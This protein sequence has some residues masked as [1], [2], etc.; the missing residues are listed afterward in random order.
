MQSLQQFLGLSLSLRITF[1]DPF[2]TAAS[3][4]AS[5]ETHRLDAIMTPVSVCRSFPVFL[6]PFQ[7]P[8]FSARTPQTTCL[9]AQWGAAENT[10]LW[11]GTG[12]S[13]LHKLILKPEGTAVWS[14][15]ELISGNAFSTFDGPP[16]VHR[17]IAGHW[18]MNGHH[19]SQRPTPWP[20]KLGLSR[21]AF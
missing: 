12:E 8:G 15:T 4:K 11:R 7:G 9:G 10:A 13:A 18:L 2:P 1:A 14:C 16:S 6:S 5:P 21:S 20:Q 19:S 17:H 3:D